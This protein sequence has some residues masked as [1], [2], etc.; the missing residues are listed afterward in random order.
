M[1][2]ISPPMPLWCKYKS[3]FSAAVAHSSVV[4]YP[5]VFVALMFAYRDFTARSIPSPAL[6]ELKQSATEHAD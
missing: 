5:D 1:K 3:E 4:L 6:T 2:H